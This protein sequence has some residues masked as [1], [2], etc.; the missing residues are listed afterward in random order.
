MAALP[1]TPLDP[2]DAELVARTC[3]GEAAA[4]DALVRRHYRAAFAVALAVTGDRADAEDVCQDA[5]I[6]AAR[7]LEDCRDPDRFAAWLCAIVRN[8]ARN[9]LTRGGIRGRTP[10]TD[11]IPGAGN[12]AR[13]AELTELRARLESAL[14]ALSPVQRE[15][16]LLHDLDGWTHD[17]IAASIGTSGGMS[18]Q[19]LFNA[20]RRLR[21]LLGGDI[22]REFL[23]D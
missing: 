23:H 9:A 6:R 15:V 12:S 16:V 13:R 18:R 11:A 17:A 5:F 3:A 20:R 8:Q 4:F 1:L 21:E 10:L 7:R 22:L 14:A 2:P 19:H